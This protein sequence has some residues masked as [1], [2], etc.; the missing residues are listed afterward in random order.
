MITLSG[1]LKAQTPQT[2]KVNFKGHYYDNTLTPQ[3]IM[4][5]DQDAF[6]SLT[7]GDYA[8]GNRSLIDLLTDQIVAFY[9]VLFSPEIQRKSYIIEDNL[10]KIVKNSNTLE[11]GLKLDYKV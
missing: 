2:Q 3:S 8:T 5:L 7:K 9:N 6:V 10:R 4:N 1:A 11:K